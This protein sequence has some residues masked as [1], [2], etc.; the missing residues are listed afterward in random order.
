MPNFFFNYISQFQKKLD[1]KKTKCHA[2]KFISQKKK[3]KKIIV[4]FAEKFL[5]ISKNSDKQKKF[6]EIYSDIRDTLTFASFSPV[7]PVFPR[8]AAI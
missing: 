1:R 8:R 2:E 4:H 6:E 7:F 5:K 3:K